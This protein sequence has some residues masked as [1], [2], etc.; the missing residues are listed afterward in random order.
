MTAKNLSRARPSRSA[1]E[2]VLEVIRSG[3][4]DRDVAKVMS[5]YA[6]AIES[7][8]V[9]RNNPPSRPLVLRGRAALKRMVEDICSREMSHAIADVTVGDGSLAY[10]VDCRYPDGCNVIALYMATVKDGRIVREF[11]IDCWDE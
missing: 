5:A 3:Y 10:R 4:R 9:N 8:I 11:S 6:E 7:T 1:E 2:T